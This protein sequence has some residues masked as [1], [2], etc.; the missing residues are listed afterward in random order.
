MS[1]QP[2]SSPVT[3]DAPPAADIVARAATY[4]RMTRYL[5]VAMLLGWGVWSIY[6]GFYKWPRDNRRYDEIASKMAEAQKAGRGDEQS[7]LAAE[8]KNYKKH[9]DLDVNLNRLFGIVFPPLGIAMLAW[10][11]YNSRG[12]I[13]LTT[14][15]VLHAPGHPPVPLDNLSELERKLW[16]RKGIAFVKY[17]VPGSPPA[18][19]RLDDFV[20]ERK[21]IDAIYDRIVAKFEPPGPTAE[22]NA[23]S[24]DGLAGGSGTA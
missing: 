20:Y 21:P 3:A 12:E 19:I 15:D 17:E 24:G 14:G 11:L 18:Q 10:S 9:T 16:D 13:R 4:Y 2:A 8:L 5:I 22:A 6:D 1:D 23:T 7:K